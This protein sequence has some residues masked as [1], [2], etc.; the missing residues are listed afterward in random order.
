MAGGFGSSRAAIAYEMVSAIKPDGIALGVWA[1]E[2][3]SL[4]Q[5][6]K[7]LDFAEAWNSRKFVM[8]SNG[9]ATANIFHLADSP[10]FGL[11]YASP[12]TNT[13][14]LLV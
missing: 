12:S 3:Q 6:P 2:G 7:G 5:L 8:E 10:N 9:Q 1:P 14:L 13:R 4:L 11:A